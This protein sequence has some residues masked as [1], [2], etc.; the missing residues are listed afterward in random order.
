MEGETLGPLL[1]PPHDPNFPTR[2]IGEPGM[3]EMSRIANEADDLRPL[4]A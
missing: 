2:S 4:G 3:P 1:G